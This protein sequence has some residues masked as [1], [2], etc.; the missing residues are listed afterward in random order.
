MSVFCLL[1]LAMMCG[2]SQAFSMPRPSD[3][4]FCG[5][6]SYGAPSLCGFDYNQ[7][8]SQTRRPRVSVSQENRNYYQDNIDQGLNDL[9]DQLM[10]AVADEFGLADPEQ[11][12]QEKIVYVK[13]ILNIPPP[14]PSAFFDPCFHTRATVD[15]LT[16][17]QVDSVV[18][19]WKDFMFHNYGYNVSQAGYDPTTCSY[20]T[21]DWYAFPLDVG[22]D[23]FSDIVEYWKTKPTAAIFQNWFG[24]FTGMFVTPLHDGVVF[25]G[26]VNGGRNFTTHKGI[27]DGLQGYLRM[28]SDWTKN[29]NRKLFSCHTLSTAIEAQNIYGFY[30]STISYQCFDYNVGTSCAMQSANS[31]YNFTG[32]QDEYKVSVL[33]CPSYVF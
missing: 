33:T 15:Y 22:T 14:L 19:D 11:K 26:G 9:N 32:V 6:T 24:R 7:T 21:Q 12:Y 30:D 27:I 13:E 3:I 20:F 8:R 16:Q 10:S 17:A 28:D 4:K 31:Y 1:L 2:S 25:P 5:K 23:D 18:A 29:V